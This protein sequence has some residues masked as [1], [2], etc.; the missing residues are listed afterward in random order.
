VFVTLQVK[1]DGLVETDEKVCETEGPVVQEMQK[2][3]CYQNH[4]YLPVNDARKYKKRL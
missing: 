4:R 3:C 2:A 1:Q